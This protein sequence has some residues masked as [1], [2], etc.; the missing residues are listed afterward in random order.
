MK[1]KFA[2]ENIMEKNDNPD[3]YD[4]DPEM[5]N[6]QLMKDQKASPRKSARSS[7]KIGSG[8]SFYEEGK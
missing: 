4:S 5:Y 6:S 1:V 2:E 7:K 8:L 3:G